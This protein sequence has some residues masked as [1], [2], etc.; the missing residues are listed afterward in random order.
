MAYPKIT[1]NTG[2]VRPVIA[3]NTIPIP[4]PNVDILAGFST[5]VA[6][7]TADTN[8]LNHL[9]NSTLT[10]N[11]Q[12]TATV[13][14]LPV[15]NGDRAINTTD[16]IQSLVTNVT[17]TDLTLAADTF[18]DGNEA[19]AISRPN[20][21]VDVNATFITSGV[22]QGDIVQGSAG[23]LARV[24]SVNNEKDITLDADLFSSITEYNDG[25]II[26]LDG[27]SGSISGSSSE[28]CLLYVSTLSGMSAN[29]PTY[30]DVE[31]MTAAGNRVTFRNFP[32]GSYLPVQ[33]TQLFSANTTSTARDRACLAIW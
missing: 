6:T 27:A 21:L 33:I 31:V 26:Y 19:Y 29:A 15:V 11:D 1:V 20:H 16:G 10:G 25:Y 14:P 12:F 8:T 2:I 9:I 22:K 28:A 23:T 4:S 7:G 13:V 3:S 5:G 32:V 17:A 30:V 24:V 18:P